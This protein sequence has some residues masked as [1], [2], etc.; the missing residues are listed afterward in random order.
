MKILASLLVIYSLLLLSA[1]PKKSISEAKKQSAQIAVY[2]NNG[3]EATRTLFQSRVITLE[4][5][6]RIADAFILL[7]K[8]GQTFDRTIQNIETTY[9]A[10]PPKTELYK[11][12]QVFNAEVVGRFL[13]ILQQLKIISA[14]NQIG[15]IVSLIQ[16]AILTIARLFGNKRQVELQLEAI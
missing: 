16:T 2:A 5:K 9:G 12:F 4:Q 15:E 10:K 13:D 14:N 3:V 6:D 8:A 1:C 11:L 7:A